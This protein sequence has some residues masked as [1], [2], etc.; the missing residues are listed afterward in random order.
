MV[1]TDSNESIIRKIR[2]KYIVHKRIKGSL[3][4]KIQEVTNKIMM[5]YQIEILGEFL[6]K[7]IRNNRIPAKE[8]IT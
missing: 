3:S 7:K 6:A 2:I 8:L 5:I 4:G 1:P